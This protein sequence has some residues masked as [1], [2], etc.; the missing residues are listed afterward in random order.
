M[1]CLK[2]ECI[3][4]E[5]L[6]RQRLTLPLTR[7]REYKDLF[8]LLQP[9]APIAYSYP[10]SPPSLIYRT[11]FDDESVADELRAERII[12]KGRFTGSSVGYVLAKDLELY[13][14]AF[15][16]PLKSNNSIHEEIIE[17]IKTLGA[18]SPRLIREETG[19][20]NKRMM[21]ALHRLQEAFLVY[22]DQ[23]DDSWD[24]AWN[25]FDKEWPE[26]K[27]DVGAKQTAIIEVVRRFLKIHVLA[28]F[29]QLKD[30]SGLSI[31]ILEKV[32]HKMELDGQIVMH[33]C[34]GLGEGWLNAQDN[35]IKSQTIQPSVFMFHKMDILVRSHASE[36]K[37]KF[38]DR[39]VLQYLLID[40]A[41][42]G[43]VIGHWRIG[44]HDVDDIHLT[45]PARKKSDL[46]EK[47]LNE[48]GKQYH[49]PQSKILKYAGKKFA[50]GRDPQ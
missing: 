14:N 22:E 24:R 7:E 32:L 10:G 23:V 1:N 34:K 46:K 17:A 42:Q 39:E 50:D 25:I 21:P 27:I 26:I 13:A 11:V 4:S 43:A 38:G 47:I 48:V 20:L 35:K 36:L 8:E 18:T 37:R 44:P 40:G 29:E 16:K 6:I 31:K 49:P 33:Q 45:L 30:W 15:C 19:L 28:T 9:V 5:R 2:R 3:L 12:V 41:F